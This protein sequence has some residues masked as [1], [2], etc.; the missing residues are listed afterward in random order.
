MEPLF[1]CQRCNGRVNCVRAKSKKVMRYTPSKLEQLSA[2]LNRLSATFVF[3][4]ST[5]IYCFFTVFREARC[6]RESLERALMMLIALTSILCVAFI[7]CLVL[8]LPVPL[9]DEI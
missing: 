9:L 7:T 3:D 2:S 8:G 6:L 4:A 1:R 5:N